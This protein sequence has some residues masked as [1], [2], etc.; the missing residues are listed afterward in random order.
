[1]PSWFLLA[2]L[3]LWCLFEWRVRGENKS[4]MRL[5]VFGTLA[6]VLT[7]GSVVIASAIDIPFMIGMPEMARISV[8]A[9]IEQ[10]AIVDASIHQLDEALKSKDWPAMSAPADRAVNAIAHIGP[11]TGRQCGERRHE[12]DHLD[13]LRRQVHIAQVAAADASGGYPGTGCR[14]SWLPPSRSCARSADAWK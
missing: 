12:I 10:L 13:E 9:A 7:I 8:P 4:A 1:M 3:G 5:T 6:V 14:P 11:R 2:G